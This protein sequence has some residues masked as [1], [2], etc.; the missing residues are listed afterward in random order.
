MQATKTVLPRRV[1]PQP[2]PGIVPEGD[3]GACVLGGLL[4][5]PL[6]EVYDRFV[7]KREALS[8]HEMRQALHRAEHEWL[9]DRFIAEPPDWPFSRWIHSGAEWGHPAWQQHL[10]WWRYLML[11]FDAG[12]YG[13][14]AVSYDRRG[15]FEATDHWILLCGARWVPPDGPGAVRT[16]VLVSCSARTSPDE[17]WVESFTFLKERGGFNVLLA[18][19]NWR[20]RRTGNRH[21]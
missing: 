5:R 13:V 11:A 15:P 17:E 7:G 12:Y 10:S 16:E 2:T 9:L 21:R 14:A 6:E 19:P 8:F 20:N 3:C 1:V 18:R 4:A